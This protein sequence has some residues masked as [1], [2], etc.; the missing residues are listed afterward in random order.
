MKIFGFAGYSGS[1]KTTLIEKLIP[2]FNQ[3]GYSVSLIKHAHHDFDIDVPG[4]DSWRHRRAGAR[5]VLIS[6]DNR[7]ALMHELGE[8]GEPSLSA[9]LSRISP[10]DFVFVEGYKHEPIPKIE[11]HHKAAM[12]PFHFPDDPHVVAIAC[13]VE[14]ETALPRFHPDRADLI[15]QFIKKHLGVES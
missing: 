8:E 5:E 6:S 1:G 14:I 4:K 15:A 2:L 11:I 10:C 3:Q 12:K 13:D 7:W 9:H